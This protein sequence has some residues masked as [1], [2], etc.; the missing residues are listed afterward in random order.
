VK[1]L[2]SISLPNL[3]VLGFMEINDFDIQTC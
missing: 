3:D 1:I 2:D